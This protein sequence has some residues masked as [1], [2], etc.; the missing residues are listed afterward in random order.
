MNPRH[1]NEDSR[2]LLAILAGLVA[3][4]PL[5]IDMYL[6]AMP[7]MKLALNTDIAGMQLTISAYLIGFALFH[8]L[9]GPLADRFGRKP[10][11][12]GGTLMFIG[13]CIGCSLATTIEE[14][15][16]WRFAQGVGACVGPTLSR[17]IA[18]DIFGPSRVAKVFSLIAMLMALA[19]AV[20][21]TLG[22]VMLLVLPWP[23]V[24]VFLAVYGCAI[25]ILT[26][27]YLP[28]SLAEKQSLRPAA[29]L[30]NYGQLFADPVYMTVTVASG[31]TYAAMISYLSSSSFIYIDMLGVPVQYFGLIFLTTVLGYMG[32][33]ALSARLSSA[34]N[35]ESLMLIGSVIAV[36]ATLAMWVATAFFPTS[37]YAIMLPMTFYTTALGIVL[38]H[39][40]TIALRPFAHIAGTASAFLGFIQMSLSAGASAAVGYF[41]TTTPQ[42]M[43]LT[44]VF[45]SIT[46]L[47]LASRTYRVVSR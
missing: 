45:I 11:L 9:C 34:H 8:L 31:M 43:V 39:A 36:I 40:M 25:V 2:W 21:P 28:E 35:S 47:F 20:A 33:S 15:Q 1:L 19:P 4:G 3:L 29:I 7:A 13:A 42:P 26:S 5:S 22:G 38:P 23:S 18:R 46:A 17:T 14:L 44:M 10:V 12:L 27:R 41:L 24:F 32:G 30:K 6:P 16:A 37:L